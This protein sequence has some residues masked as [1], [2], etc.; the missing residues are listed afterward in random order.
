LPPAPDRPVAFPGW[1]LPGVLTAGAA[2]T[3]AKVHR[4]APGERLLF[5]GS[6]PLA[7]AFSLSSSTTA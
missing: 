5:A 3:I 2:Q 7:L 4:V 6:G 1:T